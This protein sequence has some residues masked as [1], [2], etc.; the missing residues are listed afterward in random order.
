M[1]HHTRMPPILAVM[2]AAMAGLHGIPGAA[3]AMGEPVSPPRPKPEPEEPAYPDHAA[4]VAARSEWSDR[5]LGLRPDFGKPDP[6]A[7]WKGKAKKTRRERR[8]GR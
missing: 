2:F 6:S 8:A 3:E 4:W 1:T 7:Q 5:R